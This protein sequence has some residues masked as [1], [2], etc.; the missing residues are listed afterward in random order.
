MS[1][2]FLILMLVFSAG[3]SL[4]AGKR[5][6]KKVSELSTD[7][8]N[9]KIK[10]FVAAAHAALKAG[11]N[12]DALELYRKAARFGDSRSQCFLGS[13]YFYGLHG[14]SKNIDK[15]KRWYRKAAEQ[16]NKLAQEQ[17]SRC[18]GKK[19]SDTKRRR[20]HKKSAEWFGK[21]QKP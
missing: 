18:F 12:S 8:K 19:A 7:E 10:V 16:G 6:G 9:A 21:S 4:T 15:A 2:F 13:C 14:V 1:R 17:L 5:D 11:E 20:F 3:L